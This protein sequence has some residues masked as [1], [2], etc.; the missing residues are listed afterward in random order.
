MLSSSLQT[1]WIVAKRPLE[2]PDPLTWSQLSEDWRLSSNGEFAVEPLLLALGVVLALLVLIWSGVPARFWRFV[3]NLPSLSTVLN[4]ASV[5]D[6]PSHK[7]QMYPQDTAGVPKNADPAISPAPP[8]SWNGRRFKIW[9]H[10]QDFQS[11]T[12]RLTSLKA[13]ANQESLE[14]ITYYHPPDHQ[15]LCAGME[16]QL[17]VT[18]ETNGR[19]PGTCLVWMEPENHKKQQS[20]REIQLT[21]GGADLAQDFLKTSGF[22]VARRFEIRRQPWSWKQCTVSLDTLPHIGRFIEITGPS[23]EEV[24][25]TRRDLDLDSHRHIHYPYPAV[26]EAYLSQHHVTETNLTL[27]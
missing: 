6:E 9:M 8:Q 13:E 1:W 20:G 11:V 4:S 26:L 7:P 2:G 25:A 14:R 21:I 23:T 17:R 3:Q 24:I 10:V 18:Q 15:P 22:R 16:L 27:D 19:Q 5:L 12:Q